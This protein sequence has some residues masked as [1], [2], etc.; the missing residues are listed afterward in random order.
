MCLLMAIIGAMSGAI[1]GLLGMLVYCAIGVFAT[2]HW[3]ALSH[4]Q[5]TALIALSAIGVGAPGFC[6]GL[7][8]DVSWMLRNYDQ[9]TEGNK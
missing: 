3:R 7:F 8:M 4:D 6:L 2:G 9:P 1:L 5:S